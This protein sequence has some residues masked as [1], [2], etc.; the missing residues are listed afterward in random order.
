MSL[1]SRM[2]HP[3]SLLL[4]LL[5]FTSFAHGQDVSGSYSLTVAQDP[6]ADD[7]I[8]AGT[9]TLVQAGGNPGTFSGVGDVELTSGGGF[10]TDFNG[11]VTGNISGTSLTIGV[12]TSGFGSIDF[13][14][15][16]MGGGMIGGTWDGLGLTGTWSATEVSSAPAEPVPALPVV[17]LALLSL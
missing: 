3:L 8:W 11:T 15:T 13:T 9:L 7:C 6:G 4:T 12:G 1:L 10:C 14:G 5:C 2:S 16:V 17:F